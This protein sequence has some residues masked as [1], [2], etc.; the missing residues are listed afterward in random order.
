[1][2][3]YRTDRDR[4]IIGDRIVAKKDAFA[5]IHDAVTEIWQLFL[6]IHTKLQEALENRQR[7]QTED[8]KARLARDHA[9]E[10]GLA[11]YRWAYA[12]LDGLLMP[13]WDEPPQDEE[14][15]AT[16]ERLF[17][18]GA[19][20]EIGPSPQK[21]FDGLSHLLTA[22]EREDAVSYPEDFLKEAAARRA[23]LEATI[24]DVS[25]EEME[26]RTWARQHMELREKWDIHFRSLHEV[27]SAFLR[28]A[29]KAEELG[30]LFRTLP[31]SSGGKKDE[32]DTAEPVSEGSPA[33]AG[34]T[35]EGG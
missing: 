10:F 31:G 2:A 35:P 25:R 18:L 19:P 16:R 3:I 21:V 30:P 32:T 9:H 14:I 17:P 5:A 29:D 7:E 15:S 23:R 34:P 26:T 8:G 11:A 24:G 4:R 28:L 22:L 6:I 1:M 20:H 13:G 27:T 12:K 33:D